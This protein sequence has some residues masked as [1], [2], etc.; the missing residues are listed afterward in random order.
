MCL[1]L[2][3][4]LSGINGLLPARI[5]SEVVW[6]STA[7]L[8][9]KPGHNIALDLVNEF[10][11]NEFK[12]RRP[13]IKKL[14]RSL[15]EL[16]LWKIFYSAPFTGIYFILT[17][18]LKNSHG[19]YTETQVSRCSKIVGSVGKAIEEILQ[20]NVI[21]D[22]IPRSPS[23]DGSSKA[24]LKRNLLRSMEWKICL[25]TKEMKDITV[26][27]MISDITFQ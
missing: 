24:K 16:N 26:D 27:L 14:F 21:Q 15:Y 13:L 12:G 25:L 11:N 4:Y 1:I 18:N 19:Q 2:A 5:R 7:N 10:L 22:Y 20:V 6:N 8:L 3:K 23:S 17:A 9:G